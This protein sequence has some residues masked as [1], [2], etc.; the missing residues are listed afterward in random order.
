MRRLLLSRAVSAKTA[1]ATY[2]PNEQTML[3]TAYNV[4]RTFGFLS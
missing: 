2:G 4:A 1:A 3:Q